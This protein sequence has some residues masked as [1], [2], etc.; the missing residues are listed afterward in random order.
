M[1]ICLFENCRKQHDTDLCF[2]DALEIG[3]RRNQ[4]PEKFVK[5]LVVQGRERH[6]PLLGSM[7][8]CKLGRCSVHGIRAALRDYEHERLT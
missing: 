2:D 4:S 1:S 6:Q 8:F 7:G 3:R 5:A